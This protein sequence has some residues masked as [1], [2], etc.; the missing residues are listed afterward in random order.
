MVTKKDVVDVIYKVANDEPIHDL[1][2]SEVTVNLL[3]DAILSLVE[4][5]EKET[6]TDFVEFLRKR[7]KYLTFWTV[8]DLLHGLDKSLE[9]FMNEEI[10]E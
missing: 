10:E 4:Q 9:T 3:A 2:Y 7:Y 5:K 6:L 8:E 1:L